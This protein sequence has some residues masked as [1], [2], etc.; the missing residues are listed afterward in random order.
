MRFIF[1]QVA[2]GLRTNAIMAFSVTL[3][4]F[5]SLL[6]VGAAVLF[7]IQIDN[8]KND[9]YDKVEVTVAMCPTASSAPQCAGGEATPEQLSAVAEYIESPELAPYVEKVYFESKEDAFKA[10]QKQM[11]GTKWADALTPEQMQAYYRIKLVNPQEYKVVAEAL[12]G[13]PGVENVIDQREQLEP[14]FNMLN[15]FTLIS[16]ALAGIM[17]LTAAMLIPSTIRLSAMFRKNETE[18]MRFVG[19][20]NGFIQLPFILEGILAALIGA[21]LSVV[22]L[23]VAVQFFLQ[24]WFADSWLRIVTGLDV[25]KLSPLLLLGAVVLAAFASFIALR[26]YTRV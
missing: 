24:G 20:S 15:R 14:L 21:V 23:W 10:F 9:W 25:L 6:F 16:L 4:T 3:V 1:S 26:K 19:A 7:Q 22:T 11:E 12:T 8:L 2:K 13:R 5:V 18:I 17:I